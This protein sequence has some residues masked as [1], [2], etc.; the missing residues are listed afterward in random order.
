MISLP[1]STGIKCLAVFVLPLFSSCDDG[2]TYDENGQVVTATPFVDTGHQQ[3]LADSISNPDTVVYKPAEVI[4]PGLDTALI[5]TKATT[6]DEL[7]AYAETQLGVR[8]K[9]ASINPKVGFDCSGFIT[10]VFNHFGIK[11]PRSSVDFTHVG[12]A[13]PVREAKKGD[14]ILFTGTNPKIRVVGHMGIVYS[15]DGDEIK[16]IHSSS[17]KAN[18]VTISPLEG[19]YQGRFMSIRRIFP[20]NY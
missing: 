13:I 19:Y 1:L 11:V 9:Y 17:G 10:Y 7:V 8:Y 20:Q 14:L 6:P 18:G 5:N 15:V 4:P 12:K 2:L 3:L 16:F